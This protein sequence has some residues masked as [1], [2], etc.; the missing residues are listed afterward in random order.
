MSQALEKM[1]FNP[2]ASIIVIFVECMC[3]CA[4]KKSHGNILPCSQQH[5][6]REELKRHL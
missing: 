6:T 1:K 5:V 4:E 3:N 2:A